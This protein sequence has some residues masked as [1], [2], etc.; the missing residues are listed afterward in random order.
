MR[1][2]EQ[3]AVAAV[4]DEEV[5]AAPRIDA[6]D[7]AL[8]L[9]DER[10]ARLAHELDVL[11]HRQRLDAGEDGVH[12]VLQRRRLA[13]GIARGKAAAD[14]EAV[15][16]HARLDDELCTSPSAVTKASGVVV[17]EPT[18]KVSAELGGDLPRLDQ[19]LRRL[20]AGD[21]ELALERDAA[22]DGRHG[23]AHPEHEV[24]R[25][26]GRLDDLVELVL[27]VEREASARRA[28]RRGG[29]R[30]AT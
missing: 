27:A 15:D 23:D 25:A 2:V 20:L 19:Q 26:A 22:V 1:R 9:G 5:V 4:V 11:L 10:A 28:R 13:V 18:W 8:G 12:E 14:V 30:G 24:A 21:A 3:H 6:H 16:H 7:Q 17:C 29:W